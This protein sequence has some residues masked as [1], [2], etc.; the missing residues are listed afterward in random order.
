MS[1]MILY[2][3]FSGIHKGVLAKIRR[4]FGCAWME[5]NPCAAHTF[6]FRWQLC[7]FSTKTSSYVFFNVCDSKRKSC[8][9][10]IYLKF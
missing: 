3:M 9:L 10:R 5:L 4:D 1:F 8:S 7:M 2:S 6:F